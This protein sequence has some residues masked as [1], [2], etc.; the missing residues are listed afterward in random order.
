[1]FNYGKDRKFPHRIKGK[2]RTTLFQNETNFDQDQNRFDVMN[3]DLEKLA[4]DREIEELQYALVEANQK[5]EDLE[6]KM[7]QGKQ[8]NFQLDKRELSRFSHEVTQMNNQILR[9]L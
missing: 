1:M 2:K 3:Q 4:L 7:I 9:K 5:T 6:S 8:Q